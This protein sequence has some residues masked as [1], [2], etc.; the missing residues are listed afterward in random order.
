MSKR[1][2]KSRA[3]KRK[4]AK[5]AEKELEKIPKLST[6]FA[7]QSN[8]QVQAHETDSASSDESYPEV[9]RSASSEVEGEA[10]CSTK[11]TA[12]DIPAAAGKEVGPDSPQL[13]RLWVVGK[14]PKPKSSRHLGLHLPGTD[15][16]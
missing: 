14:S 3:S 4:A 16:A 5:D 6:Y 15:G 1:T 2:Y 12:T 7:L 11:Q 9:S 13:S 8:I 10:S